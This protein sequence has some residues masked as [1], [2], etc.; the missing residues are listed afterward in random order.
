M[1]FDMLS[2]EATVTYDQKQVSAEVVREVIRTAD[3]RAQS[4]DDSAR[5]VGLLLGEE[6]GEQRS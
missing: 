5:D 1:A 6:Q 2:K 3:S 4:D